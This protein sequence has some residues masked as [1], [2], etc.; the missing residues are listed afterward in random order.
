[1][2]RGPIFVERYM[3]ALRQGKEK[4]PRCG[5]LF[6]GQERKGKTSL[7]K[8]I[9][10]KQFDPEQ[11]STRGIDNNE[12]DTVD[13]RAVTM[14]WSEKSAVD[15]QRERD[16]SHAFAVLREL[17]DDEQHDRSFKFQQKTEEELLS[18]IEGINRDMKAHY[19]RKPR[20]QDLIKKILSGDGD[21]FFNYSDDDSLDE[22]PSD[23][24]IPK[25][26]ATKPAPS[27]STT[28]EPKKNEVFSKP[29][30]KP[31]EPKVPSP[32]H[33]KKAVSDP[34]P[35]PSEVEPPAPTPLELIVSIPV[36]TRTEAKNVNKVLKEGKKD[37]KEPSLLLNVL[38]FAGQ[39][40]YRPMHHCFIRRR[41]MYIVVF[42]LQDMCK[43][44]QQADSCQSPPSPVEEIRYWLHSI[45][46]HIYPP[47]SKER[48]IDER[49]RRVVLVGTHQ[50]P[51]QDG[52]E[53][54]EEDF[55]QID[56]LLDEE[57]V[58]DVRCVDHLCKVS[59]R[60]F[61]PVENS[62]KDPSK[63]GARMLQNTLHDIKNGLQ[64]LEESYPLPWLRFEGRLIEMKK[65]P[66]QK[67]CLPEKEVVEIAESKGVSNPGDALEFFH[68]IGEIILLRKFCSQ[69]YCMYMCIYKPLRQYSIA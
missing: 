59:G 29:S 12:V 17:P 4:I 25:S 40:N 49:Q 65:T 60:W 5:L 51:G 20:L 35:E 69:V 45:H 52:R 16:D 21:D 18:S 64:F 9:V 10:G 6:L 62:L 66:N 46:A 55:R 34:L 53:V 3:R 30:P 61:I 22:M 56:K 67:K 8:L 68:D 26:P 39:K 27:V 50:N 44:I 36:S 2:K 23:P 28:V 43:Y 41:S 1:M 32:R 33:P 48:G 31:R 63:S 58:A 24:I 54:T 15:Q 47:E 57:I 14:N 42:N 11:D 7:Y 38:D 37:R 13:S 19:K